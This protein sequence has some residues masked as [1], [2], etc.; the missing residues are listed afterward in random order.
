MEFLRKYLATIRAQLA[1][2]TVSQKLLITLLVVFMVATIFFT[3]VL[4]A[5]PDMVVLM[6]QSMSA[7]EINRAEMSLKGKYEYQ[8]QGDKILVPADK[9]Y[10]I[11]GELFAEQALPKDTTTAFSSWIKDNNLLETDG[12]SARKWNVALGTTLATT[13]ESFPYIQQATVIIGMGE[14][15]SLGRDQ[16]PSSATVTLKTRGGEELSEQ[17]VKSIVDMVCGAV[18]GMKPENVRVT[19]GMRSYR[20]PSD[21]SPMPSDL[22]AF[23][24][25]I[26]DSLAAKLYTM[27]G[28]IPEVKIAVNAVPDLSIRKQETDTYDPKGIVKA[29]RSTTSKDTSSSEGSGAGEPGVKPN[30]SAVAADNSGGHKT[31]MTSNDSTTDNEVHFSHTVENAVLP[32]GTNLKDLTASISIPR[33]YFVSIYHRANPDKDKTADPK[34]DDLKDTIDQQSKLAKMRAKNAIGAKNEDQINVDWFDD[35]IM[36]QKVQVAQA[37]MMSGTIAS[38]VTQ[39]AK[40]I[41]LMLFATIFLG[42]MLMMVR[43]AAPGSA[44]GEVDPSVFF[45]GGSGG[46]GKAKRKPGDPEQLDAGDDVFGEANEGEA[47]LTGIELDDETIQSRKMV[48][49]VSNMIKEN[50]ENATALVKRWMSKGK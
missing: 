42:S 10:E 23:K 34:D 1:G 50:P 33:S 26:E 31:S 47:V 21:D 39:Y 7:E 38:G 43:K 44:G 46:G 6:P 40:P 15:P 32:A 18:A 13:L 36:L 3:V 48:D 28:D 14:R 35:T 16:I 20:A 11:R 19:D 37:G 4:S 8:V 17:K 25:S 49:E 22:L 30:V 9:A 45:G 2:L 41:G 12:M 5:K 29:I 27:F 24:K